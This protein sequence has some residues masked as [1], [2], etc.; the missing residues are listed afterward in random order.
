[1]YNTFMDI[2]FD[3]A[4]NKSNIR[5]HGI[6]LADVEAVF[7]DPQAVTIEDRDHKEQRFVTI[8]IDGFGRLVVVCYSYRSETTIR[9]ISA[10]KAEPRE[11][12]AYEG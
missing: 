5:K 3:P 1:M 11:R 6:S 12:K 7:Y 8:G 2:E 10:R 9:L 4:K